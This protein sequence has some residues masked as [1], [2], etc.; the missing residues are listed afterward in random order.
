LLVATDVRS[1]AQ[2]NID[3]R[4]PKQN[5]SSLIIFAIDTT[6]VDW[7]MLGVAL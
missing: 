4:C 2:E 7:F 1:G 3:S 5:V 6:I